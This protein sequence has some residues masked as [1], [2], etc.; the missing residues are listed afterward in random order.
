MQDEEKNFTT[1]IIETTF[2]NEILLHIFQYV[3]PLTLFP[4][5]YHDLLN[6]GVFADLALREEIWSSAI[7]LYYPY[8]SEWIIIPKEILDEKFGKERKT[9]F[10]R[11]SFIRCSREIR[12]PWKEEDLG[13]FS[14]RNFLQARVPY[15][16][17]LLGEGEFVLRG[18]YLTGNNCSNFFGEINSN[19]FKINLHAQICNF[20]TR[21]VF[22]HFDVHLKCQPKAP[23]ISIRRVGRKRS[24]CGF[25]ICYPIGFG[26]SKEDLIQEMFS[27]DISVDIYYFL[28]RLIEE[29]YTNYSFYRKA[30][31]KRF[32]S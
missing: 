29:F 23:Y 19:R 13:I 27:L 4:L 32:S 6:G 28:D 7:K 25:R 20:E 8:F 22:F 12:S 11:F 5:V 15:H 9:A 31:L 18:K 17:L 21:I 30:L 1:S 24:R 10:A 2:S 14:F 16:P 26:I 3:D